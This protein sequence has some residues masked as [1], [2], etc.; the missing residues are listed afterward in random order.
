MYN[1]ELKSTVLIKKN[2]STCDS[3]HSVNY[4]INF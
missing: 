4:G 3:R 2:L 1:N